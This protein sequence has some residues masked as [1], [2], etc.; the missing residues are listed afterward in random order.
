L[1][2]AFAAAETGTAVLVRDPAIPPPS[3]GR[4]PAGSWLVACTSGSTAAPRAVCRTAWSWAASV[5]PLAR[6]AGLTCADRVL[7]TGPLHA[8]LH[9]HAAVHTLAV[10]AELTDEAAGA[11]A[12]HAVPAAL[13]SLLRD[14]PAPAPLR[15]AVVAGAALSGRLADL[16]ATRG[17][18]V[19]EYYGAAELSFVA[20]RRLPEPVL[21]PFPGARVRLDADGTVWARSPYLALGYA[22]TTH[23]ADGAVEPVGPL[24]SS[25][26]TRPLRTDRDGF[27][28]VG[29]LAEPDGDP[30]QGL[31]IR[32]R[33]DSAI[34][35]G[36]FTVLAEDV[37]AVLA[38][39]PGVRAVAVVGMP[40][41]RLGEL[42]TAVL[43]PEL[44]ADLSGVPAA[45]RRL[46]T[47]PARPRRYLVVDAL[48]RTGGGKIARAAV[49]DR[50]LGGPR[51]RSISES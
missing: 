10:G 5:A 46:L 40:H 37:E 14:L 18:V 44:G 17:L 50:L 45:A 19:T 15:T 3:L 8:T 20:I 34:T 48:P 21:R 41:P 29:D 36:G 6:C 22:R 24:A 47:G 12:V 35:T 39:L 27:A 28:T 51:S 43:E 4:L 23:P 38:L 42:V 16:A 9:L 13:E 2:H 7:L 30:G 33:G 11:T 1:A 31:V 32:G 26:A 49:R 25:P